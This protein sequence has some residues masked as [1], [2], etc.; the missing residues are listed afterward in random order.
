[1]NIRRFTTFAFVLMIASLIMGLSACDQIG[2][3]LIPAT[4]QTDELSGEIPIGVV[5]PITGR[6][7]AIGLR[8]GEGFE[9]AREEINKSRPSNVRI[10]FIIE[11]DLTTI[12]GAVEAFNKLI[13][14][15]GVPA[16]LGPASSSAARETFPIAQQNGVVAL[17]PTSGAS[18]LSAIGDY[19]F[20]A[21]LTADVVIPNSVKV[22]HAKLGYQRVV[23]IVDSVE[24]VAR[25]SDQVWRDALTES[26]V[27]ILATEVFQ[28]GDTDLSEQLTRIKDLNPDAIFI[29]ALPTDMPDIMIQ[30][31]EL[32]IPYSIPF[33]VAQVS[34]DEVR[35]AGDAAEGLITSASWLSTA[36]T[37][38][39]QAFVQNYQSAY[40]I[41]P[42]VW[43]A[44][45][46]A[47]VY[48][49]AKAIADAQ[50]A[51]PNAIR[52]ALANITDFDTILGKFSFNSVGDAVYDPIVLIV[53]NG[54][55][56][57]FE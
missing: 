9:L 37:P 3:L 31:R 6:L 22:T 5:L 24:L 35:A 11:D 4:P 1:M 51:D 34:A 28:S 7:A 15:D 29:S 55:F 53:E 42:D 2:Q 56:Q 20:R 18:G 46:Y 33:I 43:A 21:S 17:S 36:D 32:G 48:I 47:T 19:V 50:S 38:G 27:E 16:I 26:G 52:D 10:K 57:V 12:E 8:M 23:T 45:S 39:N 13:H 40:G 30:A 44:Q 54:E 14:Q 25:N 41:E 49:L